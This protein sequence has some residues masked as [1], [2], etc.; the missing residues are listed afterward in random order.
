MFAQDRTVL[1]AP[2]RPLHGLEVETWHYGLPHGLDRVFLALE[3]SRQIGHQLRAGFD[4]DKAMCLAWHQYPYLPESD[5]VR[6]RARAIACTA[7]PVPGI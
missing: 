4:A 5:M 3:V 1:R 6:A 2:Q 7:I